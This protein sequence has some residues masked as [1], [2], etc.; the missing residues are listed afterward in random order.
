MAATCSVYLFLFTYPDGIQS[1]SPLV[2]FERKVYKLQRLATHVKNGPHFSS[3]Y[4]TKWPRLLVMAS[5]ALN[6][7]LFYCV[8]LYFL[9]FCPIIPLWSDPHLGS[10]LFVLLPS[11]RIS[12]ISSAGLSWFTARVVSAHPAAQWSHF[13]HNLYLIRKLGQKNNNIVLG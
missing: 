6:H 4:S 9:C 11:P 8:V 3:H 5:F 1:K 12:G 2:D 7:R 13:T 10:L